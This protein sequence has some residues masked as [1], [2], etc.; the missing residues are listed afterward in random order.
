MSTPTKFSKRVQAALNGLAVDENPDRDALRK[1]VQSL[2]R[3]RRDRILR[4]ALR[5]HFEA[6][7]LKP[8]QAELIKLQAHLE[9]QG[10]K[11]IVLFDGRDASGK[12]GT[13]RRVTRYMNEKHYRVVALGK[14]TPHQQTELHMKRYIEQLPH[15]G[16]MVLFDRSWYNRAMVEPVMG[17][18]TK[19]QYRQFMATVCSYEDSFVA[20]GRTTLLKLYFSVSKAEQ[21]KRFERRQNDPLR[22]WKLSEVDLQAQD[23]WNEF[24]EK[25]GGAAAPDPHRYEPVV[26]DSVRRQA[27]RTPRDDE[28]DPAHDSLPRAFTEPGL[29]AEPCRVRSR[30]RGVRAHAAAGC[31]LGL[32]RVPA[33]AE[34]GE[35]RPRPPPGSGPRCAPD[36]GAPVHA[37]LRRALP[38]AYLHPLVDRLAPES[39]LRAARPP[40]AHVHVAGARAQPEVRPGAVRGHV[41]AARLELPHLGS[42]R[43]R[44]EQARPDRAGVPSGAHR[45]HGEPVGAPLPCG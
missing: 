45:P 41:R 8:Y 31:G 12:G 30:R 40:H 9:R 36:L 7:A 10:R 2:R 13:I 11:A 39:F 1:L 5:S 29:R 37:R 34:Q 18:C 21:A 14:P 16:E 43:R 42:S 44:H 26:G 20:D 28:V 35:Q 23:L 15:A 32:T 33:S 38:L 17:F 19:K 24:T 3:P 25:E 4:A 22:A 27:P 6:E